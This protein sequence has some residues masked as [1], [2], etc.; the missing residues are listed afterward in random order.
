M[1]PRLYLIL[2]GEFGYENYCTHVIIVVVLVVKIT[3]HGIHGF[4]RKEVM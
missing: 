1:N 2:Q 3:I 4:K